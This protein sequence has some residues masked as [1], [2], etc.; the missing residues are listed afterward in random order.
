MPLQ[1]VSKG[2]VNLTYTYN[3]NFIELIFRTF[4]QVFLNQTLTY[5]TKLTSVE[6]RA[7]MN[8]IKLESKNKNCKPIL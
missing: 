1:K 4:T 7:F 6:V 5:D 8:F 2:S 3:W